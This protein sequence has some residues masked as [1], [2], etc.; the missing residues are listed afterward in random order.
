MIKRTAQTNYRKLALDGLWNNNPALIQLLGLCPLLAVTTSFVN[1]AGLG[2]ATLFVLMLSNLCV[3]LSAPLIPVSI[4]LPVYV[5]IISSLVTCVELLIQAFSFGLYSKLGIFLPLI[6][7]NCT[8]LGRAEAF[9]AN[10]PPLAAIADGAFHGLG[11]AVILVLLGAM[12]ELLGAGHLFSD[13]HL[14][15]VQNFEGISIAGYEGFLLFILPPGGFILLG[16]LI[17][18]KNLIVDYQQ[19]KEVRT[20]LVPG[21]KRIRV[22]G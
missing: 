15:G 5:L 11:F 6:V 4:R 22:S 7:T 14:L 3:S 1:G 20:A 13:L 17:V 9:A 8:I 2:I 12:R 19:S 10:N 16:L 18:T 21:A